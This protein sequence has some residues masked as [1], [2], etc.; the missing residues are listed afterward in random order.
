MIKLHYTGLPGGKGLGGLS[1]DCFCLK[2]P[3][4]QEKEL[5]AFFTSKKFCFM[6]VVFKKFLWPMQETPVIINKKYKDKQSGQPSGSQFGKQRC[7]IIIFSLSER[8]RRV[9]YIAQSGSPHV[10]AKY[11]PSSTDQRPYTLT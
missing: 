3:P 9:P 4:L 6:Y 11:G 5:L 8:L 7:H 1:Y 10:L 2:Q